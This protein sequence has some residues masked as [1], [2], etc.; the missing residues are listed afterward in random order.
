[1]EQRR[2]DVMANGFRRLRAKL[3]W[4]SSWKGKQL[5]EAGLILILETHI[6]DLK[7]SQKD[8]EPVCE[9]LISNLDYKPLSNAFHEIRL[10]KVE[11]DSLD[12]GSIQDLST[13]KFQMSQERLENPPSYIALSYHWGQPDLVQDISINNQKASVTKN[14][15]RLLITF[16]SATRKHSSELWKAGDCVTFWVD[17][18]CINQNDTPEKNIQV[19]FM[20]DIYSK[21]KGVV[22]YIGESESGDPISGLVAMASM[23]GVRDVLNPI[24]R[25]P[26]QEVPDNAAVALRE[27]WCQE[28]YMRSWVVQEMVLG[29]KVVCLYGD[30]S[31]SVC[32]ELESLANLIDRGQSQTFHH[33][34]YKKFFDSKS[35][36]QQTSR[37]QQLDGWR[38]LREGREKYVK[39]DAITLL[40]RTRSTNS[41]DPRDKV[42]SLLAL[43]NEA[44]RSVIK[45][46]YSIDNTVQKVYIDFAQHIIRSGEGM[47]LLYHAGTSRKIPGLPTWVPD[48]SFEPRNRID[49]TLY[50]TTGM[51]DALPATISLSEDGSKIS[52]SAIIWDVVG[53]VYHPLNY[54]EP[55]GPFGSFGLLTIL[56]NLIYTICE[57]LKLKHGRY[58]CN[59]DL[60]DIIWKTLVVDRGWGTRRA[61]PEEQKAYG[62][63]L[64]TL[65]RGDPEIHLELL[66]KEEYQERCFPLWL[67]A[68]QAQLGRVLASTTHGDIAVLP[69]DAKAGDL[70][71]AFPCASLPF[72]IRPCQDGAFELVG[73]CYVYGHMDGLILYALNAMTGSWAKHVTEITLK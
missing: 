36:P 37:M 44:D 66:G 31:E 16:L 8:M 45:V 4:S 29:S 26:L 69:N 20:G 17:A 55:G 9:P 25:R 2:R 14:L 63:F 34:E 10:L 24:T 39:L 28:W 52:L 35:G 5:T 59:A 46:N 7:Q 62:A 49:E 23:A 27:L 61:G 42:Y 1:M 51:L 68:T 30:Q 41:T 67:L 56:E 47:K 70:I 40:Y 3:P 21:A 64:E 53:C 15:S 43:L 65:P 72:V 71:V 19:Q 32:V 6:S 38:R 13:I 54:P 11:T 58:P 18:L 50:H 73:T 48:W 22:G 12:F 60:N 57:K 33:P